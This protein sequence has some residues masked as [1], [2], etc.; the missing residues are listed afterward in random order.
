MLAR[1]ISSARD[2]TLSLGLS[3]ARER[4]SGVNNKGN[5]S[6]NSMDRQQ[7]GFPALPCYLLS[8]SKTDGAGIQR[9]RPCES[10]DGFSDNQFSGLR[11]WHRASNHMYNVI[12]C[13]WNISICIYICIYTRTHTL[14]MCVCMF[15]RLTFFIA[16]NETGEI[17]PS[18]TLPFDLTLYVRSR[19]SVWSRVFVALLLVIQVSWRC[20]IANVIPKFPP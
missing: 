16:T 7:M 6:I 5:L 2:R 18:S 1:K 4:H 15:P 20:W 9:G 10:R 3:C 17:P 12:H 14:P 8:V 11:S 13:S 19:G